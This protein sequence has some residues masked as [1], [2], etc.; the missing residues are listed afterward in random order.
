M[1][2]RSRKNSNSSNAE[3]WII[4]IHAVTEALQQHAGT[5]AK[6]LVLADRKDERLNA[7]RELGKRAGVPVVE[8]DKQALDR[9]ISGTHQGVAA[10]VSSALAVG[11][12][13]QLLKLL[14]GIQHD[15]L[16]LILDSIT[17]PHNLGACLRTADAAGVDAVIM[18][19]D[20]SAPLN[21]TVRKVA[22]GA[23]ETVAVFAVTNLARCMEALQE[24]GIWI[25]GTADETGQSFYDLE[26]TGPIAITMGSE[27][28]GLRRLTR[29]HCDYLAAIPMAGAVSSLNVS[30]AT[31]I[32]LFEAVRQRNPNKIN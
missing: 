11:D 4:G 23:A 29:E 13:K 7:V 22:C 30:V 12:E 31:G 10:L 21:A 8:V 2:D 18:P 19:K 24:R 15:P 1:N 25:V 20:K 14:D 17:D 27:G 3:D 6:V 26:L 9:Q 32:A 5:L 28:T 16:L